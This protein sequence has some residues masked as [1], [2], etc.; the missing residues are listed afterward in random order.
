MTGPVW[1]KADVIAQM[2]GMHPVTVLRHAREGRIPAQ[3]FG[4]LTRFDPAVIAEW[5]KSQPQASA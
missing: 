2:V 3:K 1:V 4:R 5:M